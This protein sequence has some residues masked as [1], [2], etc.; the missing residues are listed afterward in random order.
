MI[1]RFH[2]PIA[3]VPRDFTLR[4]AYVLAGRHYR[5]GWGPLAN[6]DNFRLKDMTIRAS[7]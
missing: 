3:A 6:L 5:A 7:G 4:A 1:E 2:S